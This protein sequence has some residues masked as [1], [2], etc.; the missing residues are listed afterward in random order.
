MA[1]EAGHRG[2]RRLA[3][4]SNLTR[5]QR[6]NFSLVRHDKIGDELLG[7]AQPVVQQTNLVDDASLTLHDNSRNF[8]F[9]SHDSN[10][11]CHSAAF[12]TTPRRTVLAARTRPML[13]VAARQP[14][15]RQASASPASHCG[16]QTRSKP[17]ELPHLGR[18]PRPSR[19]SQATSPLQAER[20][21]P[22]PADHRTPRSHPKP[23]QDTTTPVTRRGPHMGPSP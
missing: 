9:C 15:A 8:V 22:T 20:T 16:P 5:G 6:G 21:A 11:R 18:S 2:C 3:S 14:P 12:L 10:L 13:E 7:V 1:H 4:C 17:E 23:R 19:L